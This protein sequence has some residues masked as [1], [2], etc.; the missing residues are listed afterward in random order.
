MNRSFKYGLLSLA[1]ALTGSIFQSCD[2]DIDLLTPPEFTPVVYCLLNPQD[3]VQT[4]R[5]SRVFQDRGQLLE[6]ER[7]YDNY[8]S[9]TTKRIYLE[10]IDEKGYRSIT[11]FSFSEKFR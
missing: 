5:I 1:I 4:A 11:D 8:L 9:D 10:T 2:Q 7:E 3:S 6:W